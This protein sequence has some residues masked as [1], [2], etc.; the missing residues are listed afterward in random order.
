MEKKFYSIFKKA[1]NKKLLLIPEKKIY[2]LFV[3]NKLNCYYNTGSFIPINRVSSMSN[4]QKYV[5]G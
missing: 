4:I 3:E 1:E 5:I 2:G